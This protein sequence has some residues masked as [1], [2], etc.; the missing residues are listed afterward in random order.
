ML[1][2]FKL[3]DP[4]REVPPGLRLKILTP[5]EV[6]GTMVY[7]VPA[8]LLL[9]MAAVGDWP[10]APRIG[11]V[12]FGSLFLLLALQSALP[13]FVRAMATLRRMRYGFLTVGRIVSC[14]LAWEKKRA[15]TA[16]VEFLENWVVN[17]GRSQM[18]KATGCFTTLVL[19]LI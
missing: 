11:M 1:T 15:E 19:W 17:V 6:T 9:G 16:Y 10:K 2:G 14:H 5:Y 3:A 12:I 13:A 4:P 8:L 7:T 18:A